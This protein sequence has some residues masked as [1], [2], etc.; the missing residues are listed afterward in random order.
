V[1]FN[2]DR[3]QTPVLFSE[4]GSLEE[5]RL[6]GTVDAFSFP[7][8]GAYNLAAKPFEYMVF[9]NA[10]HSLG[11]TS[12][13]IAAAQATVD[14]MRFW[15]LRQEDPRG[16]RAEQFRRWRVIRDGWEAQKKA[17]PAESNAEKPK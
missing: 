8:I 6:G 15:I 7:T 17:E 4:T 1:L 16:G 10:G 2:V 13:R 12:H 9:K 3:V 14:W 5:F 11:R